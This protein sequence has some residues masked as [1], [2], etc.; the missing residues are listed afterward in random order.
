MNRKTK[1]NEPYWV[2]LPRQKF[3]PVQT[4]GIVLRHLVPAAGV[5]MFDWSA[6]EFL[7]LSLFNVCFSIVCIG[8]VGV[9]VSTRQQTGP[10]PNVMDAIAGWAT[11][12]A[13]ALI[14]SIMLTVM[15]GWVIGVLVASSG[16]TVFSWTLAGSGL[17][18]VISAAPASFRQY[19]ADLAAGLDEEQRKRRDQPNVLVLVMTGGLVF[20]LS[21]FAGDF[22]DWALYALVVAVTGLFL[23]RDLRPDLMRELV[24]PSRASTG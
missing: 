19:K 24:R 20:I 3:T 7:M 22:G 8:V 4:A 12:I 11:G 5:F 13:L 9:L 14:G 16:G 15:F 18:M 17:L 1:Q 2:P 6:G 23:F 10:S 21:G